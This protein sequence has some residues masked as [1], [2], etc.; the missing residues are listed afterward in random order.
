MNIIKY[1]DKFSKDYHPIS[2]ARVCVGFF[3]Q[4]FTGLRISAYGC[5]HYFGERRANLLV[6]TNGEVSKLFEGEVVAVPLIKR[7]SLELQRH[8]ICLDPIV[9]NQEIMKIIEPELDILIKNQP[10]HDEPLFVGLK[11]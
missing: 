8:S 6:L 7:G 4:Y 1:I 3:L 5:L 2:R 11:K 10:K 9:D